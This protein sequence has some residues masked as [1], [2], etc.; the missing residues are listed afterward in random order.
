MKRLLYV[1]YILAALLLFA[2]CADKSAANVQAAKQFRYYGLNNFEFS[3]FYTV[4]KYHTPS[5]VKDM[6]NT[7]IIELLSKKGLLSANKKDDAIGI[8]AK[9]TRRYAGDT[10]AEKK[11]SLSYPFFSYTI[12]IVDANLKMKTIEKRNVPFKGTMSMNMKLISAQLT[13]KGYEK[14]F[15]DAFANM[16]VN[17]IESLLLQ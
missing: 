10:S 9:Y 14:E 7:K 15:V 6:L 12:K 3:E 1:F 4:N 5:Q 16:I 13:D 8:D 17:D 11:S 2:G